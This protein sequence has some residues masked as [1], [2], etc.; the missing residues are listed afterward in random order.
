MVFRFLQFLHAGELLQ[1][2]GDLGAEVGGGIQ[3]GAGG[4]T[5]DGQLAQTRQ[6]GLDAFDTQL[7]LAGVA[8]EFLAQGNRGGIHQVGAAGLDHISEFL[9]LLGQGL[10]EDF[11]ARDEVINGSFRSSHVR[12]G[13]EGVIGR[14]AHVYVVIRV[15]FHAIVM[16]Q[17]GDDLIGVH[18]GRGTG[19]GLEYVDGEGVVM[20][21][22]GD[23][24]GGSNDGIGLIR[25]QLAGILI[26]LSAGCLKQAKGAN[27]CI[28]QATAGNR[29]VVHCALGLC[30]P[31]GICRNLNFAHGVM[32]N[33]VFSHVKITSVN[34]VVCAFQYGGEPKEGPPSGVNPTSWLACR[35]PRRNTPAAWTAC[36][37]SRCSGWCRTWSA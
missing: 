12:S 4:G 35:S 34:W 22:L 16:R 5:A 19:A 18:I 9:G 29:E 11:Q 17:G 8:A 10:V 26:Y 21:A 1:L 20:L 23:F 36:G 31:Q 13:G 6:G 30:T 27:L 14:L 3:A 15:N 37:W 2:L 28:F 24:G 33:A 32:F 7:D 25:I